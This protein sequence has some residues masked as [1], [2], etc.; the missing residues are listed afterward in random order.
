MK[1]QELIKKLKSHAPI[2]YD[3]TMTQDM[4]YEF[5]A[6]S[7]KGIVECEVGMLLYTSSKGHLPDCLNDD[8]ENNKENIE[9][10]LSELNIVPFESL[11]EEELKF[12]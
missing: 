7:K 11:S 4:G 2:I 8:Q 1:K 3:V 12:V 5:S 6:I 9:N 10:Y